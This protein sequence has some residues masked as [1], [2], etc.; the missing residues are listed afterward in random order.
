MK[1]KVILVGAALLLASCASKAPESELS[2]SANT[3]EEIATQSAQLEEARMQ[4]VDILARKQFK[5]AED[6]FEN[7]KAGLEKGKDQEKIINDLRFSKSYLKEARSTAENHKVQAPAIFQAR[8][9][10]LKAGVSKYS[11]LRKEW[12]SIDDDVASDANEL[13]KVSTSKLTEYQSRYVQ[14]E[15]HTVMARE[16]GDA[17]AKLNGA[18]KDGISK[19]A[20]DTYRKTEMSIKAAE[21]VIAANVKNPEGYKDAVAQANNNA[22]LLSDVST[23]LRGSKGLSESAAIKMV[24]Q[25]R[26]ITDL[27]GS[28]STS[29]Q[30][31]ATAETEIEMQ[32]RALREKNNALTDK[33]RQLMAANSSVAIQRAIEKSR[34]QFSPSEAEAY[35][36]GDKLLIR[37]KSMHF[38][39]GKAELPEDSMALLA[40]VADVAKSLDAKAVVVEGHTDSVGSVDINK[41]LSEDRAHSVATYFKSNGLDQAS[42]DAEGY[43]FEKPIAS[44]KTK[45]GRAQNRRVDVI[46]TPKSTAATTPD[47]NPTRQ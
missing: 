27:K 18:S 20:S 39:N 33:D 40:K 25:N 38:A 47:A 44:N 16:L 36:Q 24:M 26:Q 31:M 17:K 43:G 15:Q 9:D 6:S 22:L 45:T 23:T 34:S 1:L 41:K 12:M 32:A 21:T 46:I 5:Q 14:L 2:S 13:D 7:A 28:L 19:R 8:Q 35:Q 10:A 37:L 42:I 29:Q 11:D 4:N 3:R 30:N